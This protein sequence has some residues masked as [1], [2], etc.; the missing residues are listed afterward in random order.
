M[1]ISSAPRLR[2][3][4]SWL[5]TRAGLSGTTECS[6]LPPIVITTEADF[7]RFTQNSTL[8]SAT[9]LGPVVITWNNF[10]NQRL[11]TVFQGKTTLEGLVFSKVP[12]VT[13]LSPG[14]DNVTT[15]L[16][17][18]VLDNMIALRQVSMP[19]LTSCGSDIRIYNNARV[20]SIAFPALTNSGT[21]YLYRMYAL[22]SS[23]FAALTTINGSLT[24]NEVRLLT[25]YAISNGFASLTTIVGSLSF[26]RAAYR[27]SSSST[28][29]ITLPALQSVG[30][31]YIRYTY[32]TA[33]S[34]D[35]LLTVNGNF[36]LQ[37]L[38]TLRAVHMPSLT[39][40]SG[41]ITLSSLPLM[42]SL[43]VLG[44]QPLGQTGNVSCSPH[45]Q[46]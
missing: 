28:G 30:R 41:S 31:L 23:N 5:A 16:T 40:V 36:I 22:T 15:V 1:I 17:T 46:S 37:S 39:L 13:T 4:P 21:V 44:S 11:A 42:T 26:Y 27:S 34:L 12:S 7:L 24:L 18:I 8:M 38:P 35:A 6:G 33:I 25:P 10:T 29:P 20:T 19:G 3:L 43:C 9:A 45:C 2:L 32:A 14:L